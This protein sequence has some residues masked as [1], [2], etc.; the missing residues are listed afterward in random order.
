MREL[1]IYYFWAISMAGLEQKADGVEGLC[2]PWQSE[3][4]IQCVGDPTQ[5][6]S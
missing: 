3:K 5:S 4:S 6:E 2:T 1:V